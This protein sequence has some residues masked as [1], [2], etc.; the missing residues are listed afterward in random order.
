MARGDRGRRAG[1]PLGR[2]ARGEVECTDGCPSPGGLGIARDR[3]SISQLTD[4]YRA[5][6]SHIS[7]FNMQAMSELLPPQHI[8]ALTEVPRRGFTEE[9]ST[10]LCSGRVQRLAWSLCSSPLGAKMTLPDWF[11]MGARVLL[12][13]TLR[14]GPLAL[15][16]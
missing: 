6:S 2:Q 4:F 8:V 7:L 3:K 13:F 5:N 1:T 9:S 14:E 15:S 10:T 12:A 11:T 16:S